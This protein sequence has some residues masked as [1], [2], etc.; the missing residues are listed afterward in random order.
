MILMDVEMPVQDGL[1]CTRRIRELEADGEMA[2][3]FAALAAAKAAAAA[4][5]TTAAASTCCPSTSSTTATTT[6]TTPTTPAVLPRVPIIALT[7]N[8]RS[9]QVEAAMQAGCDDVILKPYRVPELV[10]KMREVVQ[11][12]R[13]ESA[14]QA[15]RA[16]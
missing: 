2:V 8:A 14:K 9:E 5:S 13:E 12:A 4:A 10:E 16:R 15:T 6:T 11:R 1:T 7:A 3:S